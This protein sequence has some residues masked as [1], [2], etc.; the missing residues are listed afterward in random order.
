MNMFDKEMFRNIEG[1]ELLLDKIPDFAWCIFHDVLAF[2]WYRQYDNEE[3]RYRDCFEMKMASADGANVALF[4]FIDVHFM[5]GF[6]IN[7]WISGFNIIN[8]TM[9]YQRSAYE[10][11]DFEDNAISMLCSDFTV[12]LLQVNGEAI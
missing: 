4:K 11:I 6:E 3:W 5:G 10:I 7:G 1:M 8:K 2:K 9:D 12:K